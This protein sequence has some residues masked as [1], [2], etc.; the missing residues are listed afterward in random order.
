MNNRHDYAVAVYI[1]TPA[2]I[3]LVRDPKKP[4]PVFWKFPGGRSEGDESALEAVIREAQ[5]EVGI[6]LAGSNISALYE[7]QRENHTFVFFKATVSDSA[8]NK[9]GNECE[10]VKLFTRE[11][12]DSIPLFPPHKQ[13]L[14]KIGGVV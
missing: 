11:Q 10:E 6:N 12:L 4:V 9:V 2:G 3:P 7:E 13:L 8:V 14:S 1:E 5:E